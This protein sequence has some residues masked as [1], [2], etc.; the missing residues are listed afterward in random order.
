MKI[1]DILTLDLGQKALEFKSE[2]FRIF[3][4]PKFAYI[5][6]SKF[7]ELEFEE[8]NFAVVSVSR[9]HLRMI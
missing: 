2:I 6:V 7:F 4:L 1:S 3:S 5:V 9:K 8:M